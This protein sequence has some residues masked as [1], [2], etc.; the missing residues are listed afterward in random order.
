MQQL[1]FEGLGLDFQMYDGFQVIKDKS[2]LN[3]CGSVEHLK[4][5]ENY[6]FVTRCN[7]KIHIAI[8]NNYGGSY[9][10]DITEKAFKENFVSLNKK[11]YPLAKEI[12]NGSDWIENPLL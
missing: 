9:G 10:F 12:W 4:K 11:I 6:Y 1:V 2:V 3:S 8:P 7:D 5:G